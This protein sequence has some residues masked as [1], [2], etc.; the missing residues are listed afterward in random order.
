MRASD[1]ASPCTRTVPAVGCSRSAMI[2]RTVD[3]P[4]PDGP[5][6]AVRLPA[7]G[8]VVDPLDRHESRGGRAELLAQPDAARSRA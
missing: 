7:G 6:R 5:T 2:R 1:G 3:L 8:D 4:H